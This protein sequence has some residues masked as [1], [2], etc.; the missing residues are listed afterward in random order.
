MK[1]SV[2]GVMAESTRLGR[3][4]DETAGNDREHTATGAEDLVKL[5]LEEQK[6][7]RENQ[8]RRSQ[9]ERQLREEGMSYRREKDRRRDELL[10]ELFNR[11]FRETRKIGKETE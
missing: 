2:Y 6:H 11:Y 1:R 9:E 4:Q 8:K 3:K 5:F 7:E 10:I